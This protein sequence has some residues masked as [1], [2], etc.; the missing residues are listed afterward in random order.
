MVLAWLLLRH[1]PAKDKQIESFHKAKDEQVQTL[2]LAYER[3]LDL[4][5]NSFKLESK[6]DKDEFKALHSILNHCSKEMR[7]L[8]DAVRQEIKITRELTQAVKDAESWIS[9]KLREP[10]KPQGA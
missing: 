2:A 9:D 8:S 10:N 3:K 6:S 7:E 1:L 5:I 4:V